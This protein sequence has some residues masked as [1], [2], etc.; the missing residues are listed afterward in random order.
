MKPYTIER[1]QQALNKAKNN[2]RLQNLDERI[3]KDILSV[4]CEGRIV[5]LPLADI[6]Y[7]EALKDYTK[8]VLV[9][10]KKLLTLGTISS[11]EDKL[12]ADFQRIHRSYIINI[13]GIQERNGR[14]VK[15]SNGVEISI[16]KTYRIK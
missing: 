4:K 16:G 9:D 10:D 15:M 3:N 5:N 1:L 8:I 13:R 6:L 12:S 14:S 2:I 7:F 11:F